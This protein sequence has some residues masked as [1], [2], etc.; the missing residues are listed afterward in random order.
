MR[1]MKY[2]YGIQIIV[3]GMYVQYKYMLNRGYCTICKILWNTPSRNMGPPYLAH[4][5]SYL[6]VTYDLNLVKHMFLLFFFMN[7]ALQTL[8]LGSED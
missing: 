1:F 6:I 7:K 5:I 4:N 8:V 3:H 2:V